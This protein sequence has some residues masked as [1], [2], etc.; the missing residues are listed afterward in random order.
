[1]GSHLTLFGLLQEYLLEVRVLEDTWGWF[2]SNIDVK[3][4]K[5]KDFLKKCLVMKEP[6]CKNLVISALTK[7]KKIF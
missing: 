4:K 3:K 2:I 1:M 7:Q 6:H 5:K